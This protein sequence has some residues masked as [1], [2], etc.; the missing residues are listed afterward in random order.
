MLSAKQ[1]GI[2]YYLLSIWYDLIW[3]WTLVSRTIGKHS[4]H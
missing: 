1:V 4:T 2:K 3:D